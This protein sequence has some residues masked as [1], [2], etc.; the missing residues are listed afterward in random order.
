[1]DQDQVDSG[2]GRRL[3]EFPRRVVFGVSV[4]WLAVALGCSG[5]SGAGAHVSGRVTLDGKP[6]PADAK[7][8]VIFAPAATTEQSQSV[9]VPVV[10]GA[11]DSPNTPVGSVKVFFD[12][13]KATGPVKKSERTGEDYQDVINLVPSEFGAGVARTV[14]GDM[15]DQNFDL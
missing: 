4:V 9:S 13:T 11:Y 15:A 2:R 12:V 10:N 1:M 14:D 7:A 3:D 8:F 5:S 6:L